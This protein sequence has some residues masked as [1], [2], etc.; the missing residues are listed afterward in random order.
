MKRARVV[1]RQVSVDCPHCD[2][3]LPNE[4]GNDNHTYMLFAAAGPVKCPNC[5]QEFVVPDLSTAFKQ[6]RLVLRDQRWQVRP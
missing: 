4:E 3:S 1:I 2:T 6:L 5:G